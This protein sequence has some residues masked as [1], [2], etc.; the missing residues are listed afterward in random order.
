MYI[1]PRQKI[2][3]ARRNVIFLDDDGDKGDKKGKGPYLLPADAT[4]KIGKSAGTLK[5]RQY[6]I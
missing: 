3:Y 6:L 1:D 4:L 2:K 5:T